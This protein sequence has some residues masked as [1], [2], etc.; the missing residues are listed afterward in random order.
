VTAPV[1]DW[2]Q[3]ADAAIERFAVVDDGGQMPFSY[4]YMASAVAARRGWAD[5]LAQA[6]LDEVWSL[7]LVNA[8]GSLRGWNNVPGGLTVY[9]IT[10]TDHV[11]PVLL[12]AYR[13]GAAGVS[14]QQVL[15]TAR[16]VMATP[17]ITAPTGWGLS[18]KVYSADSTNVYNLTGAAA[19][20]LEQVRAAG[21]VVPPYPSPGSTSADTL[22]MQLARTLSSTYQANTGHN[23]PYS[24]ASGAP[25]DA[26]HLSLL[27]EA[28]QT[29]QPTLGRHVGLHL[30]QT[31][32]AG[33]ADAALGH[34]RL[35]GTPLGL[36][37]ADAWLAEAQ[38]Y[39]SAQ[40]NSA[41]RLAQIA[42]WSARIAGG[43]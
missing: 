8:D 38:A 35:G 24:S 20:F 2:A 34:L 3:L 6:Y 33:D 7:R 28:V 29:T 37:Y 25:N 19:L 30:M 40:Q 32:Y 18:Y 15:D 12:E 43:A 41:L 23:W 9:T 26:D 39:Y 13:S 16:L 1:L 10:V 36:P 21:L 4:A 14:A 27:A 17:R 42:R 31:A 5:P 11:G 22:S